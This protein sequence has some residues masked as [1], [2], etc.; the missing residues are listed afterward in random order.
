MIC[1]E[2]Y[3]LLGRITKLHSKSNRLLLALNQELPVN[4][5]LSD[6]IFLDIDHSLIPFFIEEFE[7]VGKS[8]RVSFLDYSDVSKT[9]RLC[10]IDCYLPK[11]LL[12]GKKEKLPLE[13]LNGYEV[14]DVKNGMIGIVAAIMDMSHHPLLSIMNGKKE[15]LVPFVDDIVKSIDHDQHKVFIDAPDGLIDIYS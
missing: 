12:S 15:I 4:F 7:E 8:A 13:E 5:L 3:F 9:T 2:D 10:G 11:S 14:V 1:R 6:P